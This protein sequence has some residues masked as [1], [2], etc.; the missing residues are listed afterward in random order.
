MRRWNLLEYIAIYVSEGV[1][2]S[3]VGLVLP[4]ASPAVLEP[5]VGALELGSSG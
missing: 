3:E 2:G 1:P 5:L 4:E